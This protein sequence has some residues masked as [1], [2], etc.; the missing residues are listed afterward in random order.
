[1]LGHAAGYAALGGDKALEA[2][3]SVVAK[4]LEPDTT[5]RKVRDDLEDLIRELKANIVILI[6]ELD[7]VEDAEVRTVAQLVRAVA[8]F[9]RV[10]YLLA[11]DADR[12]A[13][14]LGGG[15][16]PGEIER[17]RAYLE[18]IV[19]LQIALPAVLPSQLRNL[20]RKEWARLVEGGLESVSDADE[21]HLN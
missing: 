4:A 6:D 2:V 13:Q 21:K 20:L 3:A 15:S 1:L 7:R 9:P 5:L 18:K 14:A 12:V 10:S 17:G 8:D 11:Y 16:A 19:Q